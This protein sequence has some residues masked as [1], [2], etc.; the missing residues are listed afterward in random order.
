[1]KKTRVGEA[2]EWFGYERKRVVVLIVMRLKALINTKS[3]AAIRFLDPKGQG[4][5][6]GRLK[7]EC[8]NF[9]FFLF[10]SFFLGGGVSYYFN[11]VSERL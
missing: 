7:G 2:V 11:S 3:Q 10:S 6:T 8:I 4:N 9:F 5:R 1:M